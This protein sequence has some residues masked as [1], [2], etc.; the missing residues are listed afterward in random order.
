MTSLS[1][2]PSEGS[3]GSFSLRPKCLTLAVF[4]LLA[5]AAAGQSLSARGTTFDALLH[6]GDDRATLILT[7]EGTE[8]EQA[9]EK[10]GRTTLGLELGPGGYPASLAVAGS[11]WWVAGDHLTADRRRVL[12]VRSG[13]RDLLE[14]VVPPASE[15]NIQT[16]ARLLTYE[17][18]VRGLVWMQGPSSR[19]LGPWA[20]TWDGS[21]FSAPRP[22]GPEASGS[23]TG[24]VATAL[25]DGRWLAVWSS[26]DGN[27]DDLLASFWSGEAWSAPQP[28]TDNGVPDVR[29][30]VV[31]TAEGALLA[32]SQWHNGRYRIVL[33]RIEQERK[34]A[35]TV[36]GGPNSGRPHLSAAANG[37]THVLYLEGT[38]QEWT[39]LE[40][41]PEGRI[42]RRASSP[43]TEER[44]AVILGSDRIV[45]SAAGAD[46]ATTVWTDAPKS[47]AWTFEQ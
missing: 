33:A 19:R 40:L 28:L 13:D 23:Q 45:F 4:A 25:A 10:R 17:G 11:R 8:R 7:S 32:W 1:P 31:T 15:Q 41:A 29:P 34:V 5:S 3:F 35:E 37:S 47:L 20:S 18:E 24:L 27:D 16:Q 42:V 12:F 36:I 14:T 21:G 44:P 38:S 22:I 43:A 26:Y 9:I 46:E 39:L 30:S 6:P 2:S